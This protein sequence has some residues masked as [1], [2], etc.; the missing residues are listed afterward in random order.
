MSCEM[1][2]VAAKSVV[3]SCKNDDVT[4]LGPDL[5]NILR[6]SYDNAKVTIDLR[7]TSILKNILRK[8][9][10]KYDSLAKLQDRLRQYSQV[11]LRYF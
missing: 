8:A 2:H 4:M 5:Q 10:L 7:R 1:S 9:F 3:Y 11:S 6:L